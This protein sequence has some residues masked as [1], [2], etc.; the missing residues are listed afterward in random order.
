MLVTE[1]S[2]GVGGQDWKQ[3]AWV[4]TR[5]RGLADLTLVSRF[6]LSRAE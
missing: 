3:Y 6:L 4:L 2:V 5:Q 1:S